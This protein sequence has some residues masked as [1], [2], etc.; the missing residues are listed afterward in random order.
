MKTA[1]SA[2]RRQ[3]EVGAEA[4]DVR[5]QRLEAE[6]VVETTHRQAVFQAVEELFGLLAVPLVPDDLLDGFLHGGLA[7]DDGDGIAPQRG[8]RETSRA[9]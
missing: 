2:G 6:V 4:G 1:P 3:A 8:A 7:A 9:A 5:L